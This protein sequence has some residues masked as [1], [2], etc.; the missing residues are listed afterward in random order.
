MSEVKA[1][2]LPLHSASYDE[3]LEI[4]YQN[5]PLQ[6]DEK[7]NFID[8]IHQLYFN[9]QN[10]GIILKIENQICGFLIFRSLNPNKI[11]SLVSRIEL[12]SETVKGLLLNYHSQKFN[13]T[14]EKLEFRIW[15]HQTELLIFLHNLK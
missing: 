8:S 2:V 12:K 14:P 5:L 11:E 1:I 13:L 6:I 10:E 4:V 9:S 15:S 3:I 7:S